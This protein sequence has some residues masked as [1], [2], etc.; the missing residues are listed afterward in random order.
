[1]LAPDEYRDLHP[2]GKAP[3][4]TDGDVT[5]A[6]SGAIIEY[7]IQKYG[8]GRA[9]PPETGKLDNFYFVH[10]AEGSLM[11][12]LVNKLMFTLI[13]QKAPL[14]LRPLL[15]PI[16]GGLAAHLI[17]PG[18]KNHCKFIEAHLER[19]G[20]W[21]AGGD[22]PT[23]ADFMMS[24]PL[25]ALQSRGGSGSIGPLTEQYVKRIDERPAYK[26]ALEKGGKYSYAS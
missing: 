6:E 14:L 18:I 26:R 5:L 10:Y 13:P 17:D 16:F 2:L 24:F 11:P 9:D 23:A 21:L 25:E 3:V 22:H 15:K 20:D 8:N 1:M 12:L 7:I 4:I 19:G